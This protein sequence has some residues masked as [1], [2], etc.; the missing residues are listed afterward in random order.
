MFTMLGNRTKKKTPYSFCETEILYPVTIISPYLRPCLLTLTP[1]LSTTTR[2]LFIKCFHQNCIWAK[3]LF[4]NNKCIKRETHLRTDQLL[5]RIIHPDFLQLHGF[6]THRPKAASSWTHSISFLGLSHS[7]QESQMTLGSNNYL[8]IS[9]LLIG[10]V[11][12]K[13][14]MS[15]ALAPIRTY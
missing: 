8:F 11:R 7:L 6:Q 1:P 4:S 13:K 2:L 9:C 14:M 10:K 12:R 5:T 3:Y 15:Q